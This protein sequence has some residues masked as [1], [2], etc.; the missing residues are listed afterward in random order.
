MDG[1]VDAAAAEQRRIGGIHDGVD[2]EPRDVADDDV[3]LKLG[4][5][6]RVQ[7]RFVHAFPRVSALMSSTPLHAVAMQARFRREREF[8]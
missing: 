2:R 3:E 5:V 1:A 8:P 6:A 7:N 4:V